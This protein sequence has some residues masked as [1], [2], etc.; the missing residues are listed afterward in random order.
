MRN[1]DR[2]INTVFTIERGNSGDWRMTCLISV[3]RGF[4]R[5]WGAKVL[6]AAESRSFLWLLVRWLP[7]LYL[8]ARRLSLKLESCQFTIPDAFK[9]P[10]ISKSCKELKAWECRHKCCEC[11][12]NA[13]CSQLDFVETYYC[14]KHFE[15]H[16][17]IFNASK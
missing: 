6:S 5:F 11:S 15:K 16:I 8:S 1:A 3:L 12:E 7:V 13:T 17:H 4:G 10:P 2:I 9:E 14:R